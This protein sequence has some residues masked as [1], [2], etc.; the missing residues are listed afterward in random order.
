MG[1]W[2]KI[3]EVGRKIK[4][5]FVGRYDEDGSV[6]DSIDIENTL[7]KLRKMTRR[8]LTKFTAEPERHL[9]IALMKLWSFLEEGDLLEKVQNRFN[10]F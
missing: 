4:E 2:D 8:S 6:E 10:G 3:K 1:L 5:F 7:T 9:R